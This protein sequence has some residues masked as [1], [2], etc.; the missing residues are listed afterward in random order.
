MCSTFHLTTTILCYGSPFS[1]ASLPSVSASQTNSDWW[2][3]EDRWGV[4][5]PIDWG[6]AWVVNRCRLSPDIT[7]NGHFPRLSLGQKTSMTSSQELRTGGGNLSTHAAKASK[8]EKAKAETNGLVSAHIW[9]NDWFLL[10]NKKYLD[11]EGLLQFHKYWAVTAS[12]PFQFSA[13][14]GDSLEFWLVVSWPLSWTWLCLLDFLSVSWLLVLWPSFRSWLYFL[15]PTCI[16]T[17]VL[18]SLNHT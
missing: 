15:N 13:F 3:H 11:R 6:S 4:L 10:K 17:I 1:P 7:K 16:L 8:R 12:L 2:Q 18:W 14:P 9:I 5:Q